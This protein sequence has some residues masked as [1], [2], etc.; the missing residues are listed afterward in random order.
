MRIRVVRRIHTEY[1]C[2]HGQH[3]ACLST[4][5]CLILHEKCGKKYSTKV[6]LH[7]Q[8]VEGNLVVPS[9][10]VKRDMSYFRDTER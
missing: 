1:I 10:T 5:I 6:A 2:I 7:L 9:S 8:I 4:E 3:V